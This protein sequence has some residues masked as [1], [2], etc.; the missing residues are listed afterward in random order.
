MLEG[1]VLIL[2]LSAATYAYLR[3]IMANYRTYL[4]DI[5]EYGHPRRC[6]LIWMRIILAYYALVFTLATA[7][8]FGMVVGIDEDVAFLLSLIY[9]IGYCALGAGIGMKEVE[10]ERRNSHI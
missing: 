7:V 10:N 4:N 8:L 2:A 1:V 6:T 3:Q 5:R 9:T